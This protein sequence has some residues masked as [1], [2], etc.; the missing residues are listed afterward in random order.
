MTKLSN[1]RTGRPA[2]YPETGAMR[3]VNVRLDRAAVKRLRR[4]GDGNLSAGTRKAAES[5]RYKKYHQLEQAII[6]VIE[7]YDL[8]EDVGPAIERL[9]TT[10]QGQRPVV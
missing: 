8:E 1:R 3:A 4:L 6:D 10:L 5:R 9:V 2:L 7:A